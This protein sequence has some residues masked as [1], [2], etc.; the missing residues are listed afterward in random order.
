MKRT[1]INL[2]QR[3][4][5]TE[6]GDNSS[7]I[8]LNMDNDSLMKPEML[9]EK[10]DILLDEVMGFDNPEA[11]AATREFCLEAIDDMSPDFETVGDL[12]VM[13]ATYAEGYEACLKKHS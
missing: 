5:Q 8:P 7:L 2:G 11:R 12:N 3:Y 9:P 13:A 4:I 6:D 1:I 10:L